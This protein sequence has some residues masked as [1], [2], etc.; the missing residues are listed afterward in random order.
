LAGFEVTT[1]G[2]FSSDHRGLFMSL[3]DYPAAI[4]HYRQFLTIAESITDR[5]G[6]ET[7]LGSLAYAYAETGNF[8]EAIRF[9][10]RVL[11]IYR[12]N[13]DK[14]NEAIVLANIELAKRLNL[15]S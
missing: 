5:P 6:E 8:V 14:E 9:Y 11:A 7:M 13:G 1:Y 10:T 4:D 2:R 3:R 15:L 12:K